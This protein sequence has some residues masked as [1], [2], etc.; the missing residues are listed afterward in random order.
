MLEQLTPHHSS[1]MYGW[2]HLVHTN[3]LSFPVKQIHSKDTVEH[4]IYGA[5]L[6]PPHLFMSG[7]TSPHAQSVV[8]MNIIVYGIHPM[9]LTVQECHSILPF[10]GSNWSHTLTH[11]HWPV[12]NR[13]LPNRVHC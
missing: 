10:I 1:V 3:T 9:M 6:T 8:I 5:H 2:S 13:L 4:W 11:L 12:I 7:L